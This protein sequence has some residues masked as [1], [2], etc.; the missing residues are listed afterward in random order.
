MVGT[1]IYLDTNVIMDFLLGR[2]SSAFALLQKAISCK[3]LILISNVV[4]EELKFQGLA[5]EGEMF[6]R[7]LQS[8]KKINI[9]L[10]SQ[11]DKLEAKRLLKLYS[12]HY[13][14]AL[15]KVIAVRY[16][17]NYFVTS[18]VRDFICFK[19]I[20]VKKPDEL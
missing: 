11:E 9:V 19:D 1:I 20:I 17:V 12:T 3:Y 16:H 14:D 5:N 4:F 6:I 2:N 18:N 7:V 13:N 15:H 10:A 8:V